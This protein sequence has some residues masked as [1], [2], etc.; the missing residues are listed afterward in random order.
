MV[1]QAKSIW[2]CLSKWIQN[3]YIEFTPSHKTTLK[4]APKMGLNNNWC[5]RRDLNSHAIARTA[6]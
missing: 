2:T 5:R 3:D 6:A 1:I 4:K